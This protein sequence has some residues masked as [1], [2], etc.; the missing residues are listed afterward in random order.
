M[1]VLCIAIDAVLFAMAFPASAQLA[2]SA[3]SECP[4]A[5]QAELELQQSLTNSGAAWDSIHERC[6]VIITPNVGANIDCRDTNGAVSYTRE[7]RSENS[8]CETIA[9]AA[10]EV[11]VIHWSAREN[12]MVAETQPTE[13]S[14]ALIAPENA[15]DLAD[16]TPIAPAHEDVTSA[17]PIVREHW[18]TVSAS[19]LIG[20]TPITP[21]FSLGYFHDQSLLSWQIAARGIFFAS[22]SDLNFSLGELEAAWLPIVTTIVSGRLHIG[23]EVGVGF[24]APTLTNPTLV[25]E[26]LSLQTF[27]RVGATLSY[28]VP[29]YEQLM[30]EF[31]IDVFALPRAPR[32][33]IAGTNTTLFQPS[34]IGGSV[35][36]GLQFS[37]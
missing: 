13:L 27:V 18:L 26:D 14:V 31:V 7:L 20:M 29:L 16:P 8:S 35:G 24:Y 9:H 25:P 5:Q 30:L 4:T 21:G 3:P 17:P 2:W 32:F 10:I 28:R 22:T 1:K 19:M 34:P 23:P 33:M 6:A 15:G 12:A 11:L 36:I 37:P